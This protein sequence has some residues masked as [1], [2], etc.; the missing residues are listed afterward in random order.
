MAQ[1]IQ[2]IRHPNIMSLIK[3]YG[4]GKDVCFL[5]PLAKGTLHDY[6]RRDNNSSNWQHKP[7]LEL[8]S[9]HKCTIWQEVI[10]LADALH[11]IVKEHECMHCD[12]NPV[13]ILVGE[14]SKLLIADFGRAVTTDHLP[15]TSRLPR[16][17][18]IYSPPDRQMTVKYDVWP[19]GCM[20]LEILVY[21]IEGSQGVKNLDSKRVSKYVPTDYFHY[22]VLKNHT[23]EIYL[24]PGVED[25]IKSIRGKSVPRQESEKGFLDA[26]LD[27]ITSM[28]KIDVSERWDAK[29]V[30]EAVAKAY[31]V[32]PQSLQEQRPQPL[33]AIGE[34]MLR[35]FE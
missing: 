17:Q 12:L 14:D 8:W 33:Q 1:T 18:P 20:M 13:N 16:G 2:K 27:T 4:H 25:Y 26:I 3:P 7:S 31:N 30:R 19:L 5:F 11:T 21:T 32:P 9:S 23:A 35:R 22:E 24:N 10:G 29:E 15:S 28:L 34:R 6:L